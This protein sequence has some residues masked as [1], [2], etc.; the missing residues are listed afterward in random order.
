[1]SQHWIESLSA[2]NSLSRTFP[3][4][5]AAAQY[6]CAQCDTI[7]ILTFPLIAITVTLCNSKYMCGTK[8]SNVQLTKPNC[9]RRSRVITVFLDIS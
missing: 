8:N 6:L 2:S 3:I 9:A 1:M 5:D 4:G 7:V